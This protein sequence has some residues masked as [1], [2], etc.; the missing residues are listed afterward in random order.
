MPNLSPRLNSNQQ[1]V[2]I[3]I[4]RPS[5]I[6]V[7][8]NTNDE[9]RWTSDEWNKQDEIVETNLVN[10]TLMFNK[11]ITKNGRTS[12]PLPMNF[13]NGFEGVVFIVGK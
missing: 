8:L 6:Y 11:T 1:I 5:T 10:L 9:G 7:A 13:T 12:I 4:Y 3:T 2:N